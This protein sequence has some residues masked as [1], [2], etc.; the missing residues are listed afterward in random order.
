MSTVS[1][2]STVSTMSTVIARCYL[3]LRWYF[4]QPPAVTAERYKPFGL[5][6][7]AG[8]PSISKG[9]PFDNEEGNPSIT[10]EGI[11]DNQTGRVYV[12]FPPGSNFHNGWWQAKLQL[13]DGLKIL[14]TITFFSLYFIFG[15]HRVNNCK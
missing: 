11:L 7:K 14:R 9:V 10:R 5:I 12:S 2:V 1:T 3:H 4:F 8:Y 6:F 13:S 15:G